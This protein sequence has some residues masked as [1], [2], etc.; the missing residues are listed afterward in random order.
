MN[1]K[2]E[3]IENYSGK[4]QSAFKGGNNNTQYNAQQDMLYSQGNQY[5]NNSLL[6]PNGMYYNGSTINDFHLNVFNPSIERFTNNKNNVFGQYQDHKSNQVNNKI[7]KEMRID[8]PPAKVC[9]NK[10]ND[11]F[12]DNQNYEGDVQT[13]E[14]TGANCQEDS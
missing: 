6:K 8:S 1:F 7:V 12:C 13:Q 14:I 3:S 11:W 5:H 9:D 4:N 10:Q 2:P